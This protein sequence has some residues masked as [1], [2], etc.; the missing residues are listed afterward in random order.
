MPDTVVELGKVDWKRIFPWVRLF[1][2]FRTAVDL[3]MLTLAC[4]AIVALSV[5]DWIFLHLPFAPSTKAGQRPEAVYSWDRPAAENPIELP[6]KLV[7]RPWETITGFAS[8]SELILRP[9]RTVLEPARTIL[10]AE[11]T[12]SEKGL[13][14]T[15]L[16]WAL[17]VWSVLA[18]AM[19]RIAAVE[20]ATDAPMGFSAALEFSL[21]NF[22]SYMTAAL[23]PI[24]GIGVFWLLC[25]IGGWIGR[26][27]VIGPPVLGLLW[28]LELAFGFLM[29]LILIAA[30]AG[31][32]L[33]YATI[34]V[35]ASDG[36]DA[37]SRSYS[38]VFTRPWHYLWFALAALV[39]GALVTTFIS[40]VASLVVYLSAA[41]V[42]SGMGASQAA[43]ML[44]GSP[45]SV[46]GPGFVSSL[47]SSNVGVGTLIAGA[48]L[49]VVGLLVAGFAASFFW[50]SS[51]V[52]YLL[53]RQVDDAT[54]FREVYPPVAEDK[55]E[56][57]PFVGVAAS[58]QPVIER[59]PEGDFAGGPRR[60]PGVS[61]PEVPRVD[62]SV[63]TPPPPSDP[64]PP[65]KPSPTS[66]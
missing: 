53:L 66:P 47:P 43:A 1:R 36:F 5:G 26:I 14:W 33:M 21:E 31:W 20:Q 11:A 29:A 25:T 35:E 6:A 12:W 48:W 50:T 7:H 10:N 63:P 41:G 17:C 23:L 46:G 61:Q 54:D 32:P 19:T 27:P 16:L 49:Q 51:T 44:F 15:R 2:V 13:A 45:D 37:F 3:R 55:D 42:A 60:V 52:I 28:G 57:R 4:A 18:G 40:V 64:N 65:S 34:G 30:V 9:A 59:P 39:Y 62:P 24:V 8:R 58:D 56:L 38:Y 22:L